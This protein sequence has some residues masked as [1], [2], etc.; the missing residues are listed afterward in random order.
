MSDVS[1]EELVA[2]HGEQHRVAIADAIAFL[3]ENEPSWRLVQP[4]DRTRYIAHVLEKKSSPPQKER[5]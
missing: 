3:D 4:I 1:V 2:L 5:P